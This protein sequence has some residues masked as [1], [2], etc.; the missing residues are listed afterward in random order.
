MPEYD[1]VDHGWARV[2]D[3]GVVAYAGPRLGLLKSNYVHATLKIQEGK[4]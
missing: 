3:A 4:K 1:S 2:S